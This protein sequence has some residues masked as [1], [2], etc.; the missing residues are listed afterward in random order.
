MTPN[1]LTDTKPTEESET[2]SQILENPEQPIDTTEGNSEELIEKQSE[3]SED[4]AA[5]LA[6][7]DDVEADERGEELDPGENNDEHTATSETASAQ[8]HSIVPQSS[9][10]SAVKNEADEDERSAIEK[11]PYDFDHSTVQ[12]AIQ[13]LPEDGDPKGRMIV[14][15]VRSHLDAPILQVVRLNELGTLPP[16]VKALLDEL[17]SE[18]PAREQAAS[19]AFEK[20]KEEKAKRTAELEAS[21]ARASQRGKKT[22]K[23]ISLATAPT[24]NA[25]A[26]E[27]RPR[28][29]V[30]VPKTSQQQMGLL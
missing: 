25:A 21:R 6:I 20:K 23:A 28:P 17:K 2:Y 27:N 19:A 18:L 14:V 15:G 26:T 7:A 8:N 5:E 10:T 11:Q 9:S 3:S 4:S 1:T 30:N 12:I 29:E 24:A 16:L 22:A 13:L